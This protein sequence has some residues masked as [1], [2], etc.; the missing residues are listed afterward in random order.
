MRDRQRE[1]RREGIQGKCSGKVASSPAGNNT[2][3]KD[4]IGFE[5]FLILHKQV[6]G[7]VSLRGWVIAY[8]RLEGTLHLHL[9]ALSP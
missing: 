4:I 9:R 7:A 1:G 3:L 5:P 8:R 6:F 2:A